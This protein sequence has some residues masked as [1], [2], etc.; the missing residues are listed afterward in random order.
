LKHV[1]LFKSFQNTLVDFNLRFKT[2][3][4]Y[5]LL[6]SLNIYFNP[7]YGLFQK[8][9]FFIYCY[10]LKDLFKKLSVV[11]FEIKTPFFHFME[12]FMFRFTP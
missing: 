8:L 1:K 7:F 6:V 5:I 9:Y 4:L 10:I 2:F 12:L 11:Y 3:L